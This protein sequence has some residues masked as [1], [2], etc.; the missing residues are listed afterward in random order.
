MC[1]R[2]RV[3]ALPNFSQEVFFVGAGS[4]IS[5]ALPSDIPNTRLLIETVNGGP[6][7]DNSQVYAPEINKSNDFHG[8]ASNGSTIK[9]V[10]NKELL[11]FTFQIP[12][13]EKQKAIRLF[14]NHED[15]NSSAK[16]MGGGDFNNYF[17]CAFTMEDVYRKNYREETLSSPIIEV[18]TP[19]IAEQ[20]SHA[21]N[22]DNQLSEQG[23]HSLLTDELVLL[24]NEPNPFKEN[25]TIN[26]FLPKEG[27][28]ELIIKDE[29]GRLIKSVKEF[30]V[31][32]FNQYQFSS[33]E[34]MTN[35]LLICQLITISGVAT[36]KMLSIH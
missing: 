31:A 20:I 29:S 24:Q 36:K 2:D 1:I 34:S 25:T 3:Y 17:A 35:G 9:L 22:K 18:L 23:T 10:S 4:Q 28:V 26:F 8:I 11:L 5:L 12:E 27:E 32:G 21:E 30:R 15:P 7:L 6:W 33:P 16:G 14:E 19:T 13:V